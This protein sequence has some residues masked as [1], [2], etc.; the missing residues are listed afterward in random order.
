MKNTAL[1]ALL[2]PV[3]LVAQ[4]PD[5]PSLISKAEELQRASAAEINQ[6]IAANNFTEAV[7]KAKAFV[8]TPAFPYPTLTVA[9]LEANPALA[10][11]H[12]GKAQEVLA[13]NA[14][15]LNGYV[16][17]ANA[18]R[19]SGQWEQA[20]EALRAAAGRAEANL[21]AFRASI[22]P[23][24]AFWVKLDTD[25]KAFVAANED[26]L[27]TVEAQLNADKTDLE[28]TWE[29]H[30]SKKKS[31]SNKEIKV[32][33]ERTKAWEE[34]A[35]NFNDENQKLAFH[36]GNLGRL[37]TIQK[38]MKSLERPGEVAD[39]LRKNASM[40]DGDVER[41]KKE[42]EEFNAKQAEA[43]KKAKKA[44]TEPA[45]E[46]NRPWVTA[47]LSDKTN[48]TSAGV[49]AKQVAF[50][51]R[52]LVLDAGNEKASKC[53]ENLKAGRDAY[54]EEPKAKGAKGKAKK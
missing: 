43:R 20:A 10:N 52:M 53:L 18:L 30:N 34:R 48:L 27:K 33:Q 8:E 2:A 29:A 47:V 44:K 6:L 31:L 22:A 7:A 4:S 19:A 25:A 9:E 51:N 45:P 15:L 35:K 21:T 40:V 28:Q 3:G 39:I 5:A 1:I 13:A 24:S 32:L 41:Q 36:K 14:S 42:I 23:I 26:R 11:E 50:L 54:F 38:A 12:G 37:D 17:Y 46:G 49:P 16:A